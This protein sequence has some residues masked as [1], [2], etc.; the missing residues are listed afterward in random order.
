MIE[1]ILAN[2]QPDKATPELPEIMEPFTELAKHLNDVLVNGPYKTKA[3]ESLVESYK[4][5]LKSRRVDL[6]SELVENAL[7]LRKAQEHI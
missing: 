6:E 7:I 1:F 3:M 4:C 5:A 2:F